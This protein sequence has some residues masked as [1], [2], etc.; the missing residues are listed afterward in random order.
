[1]ADQDGIPLSVRLE[2]LIDRFGIN[3]LLS[4]LAAICWRKAAEAVDAEKDPGQWSK[5][6]VRLG[7]V[8]EA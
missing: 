7:V 4:T 1:M 8:T 6:A 2:A 5:L 3:E